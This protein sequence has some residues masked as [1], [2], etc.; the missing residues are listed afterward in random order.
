MA[1]LLRLPKFLQL[2]IG[3]ALVANA[4]EEFEETE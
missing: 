1:K 3:K 2:E 4:S